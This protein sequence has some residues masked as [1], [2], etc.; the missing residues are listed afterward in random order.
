M[1][2]T[3]TRKTMATAVVAATE[4]MK[5]TYC[6]SNGWGHRHNN[7]QKMASEEMVAA[8]TMAAEM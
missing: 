7:Q 8:I 6:N 5:T 1:T 2:M 4:A 3:M